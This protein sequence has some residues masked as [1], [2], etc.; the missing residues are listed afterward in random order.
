MICSRCG[1][2]LQQGANLCPD[3]GKEVLAIEPED[4]FTPESVAGP[5]RFCFGCIL[6]VGLGF[7][8]LAAL[9]TNP[10]TPRL[11]A[12]KISAYSACQQFVT[13]RLKAP[14]TADFP[15]FD[16][17]SVTTGANVFT[18]DFLCRCAERFWRKDTNAIQ[19]QRP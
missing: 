8:L 7:L 17:K 5:M 15:S 19:L 12:K 11:N 4:A 3:C 9:G 18:V 6:V 14:S 2:H 13:Q 10:T 1:S 16:D